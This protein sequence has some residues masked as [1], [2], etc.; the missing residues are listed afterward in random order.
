LT[1]FVV[2]SRRPDIFGDENT[3][4]KVAARR[5]Q[6]LRCYYREKARREKAERGAETEIED[7]ERESEADHEEGQEREKST[8][9][10]EGVIDA[11]ESDESD[12]SECECEI[13]G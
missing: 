10:E 7:D 2:R 4:D 3:F 1:R 9:S 6:R 8:D 5:E 11:E 12:R 13:C